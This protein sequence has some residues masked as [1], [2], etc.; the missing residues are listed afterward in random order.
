MHARLET[1]PE[2]LADIALEMIETVGLEGV[3]RLGMIDTVKREPTREELAEAARRHNLGIVFLTPA[4][5]RS[6]PA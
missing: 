4:P 5:D 2:A 1:D 3:G 6:S